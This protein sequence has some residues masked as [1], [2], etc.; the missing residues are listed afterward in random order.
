MTT[1][2][3]ANGRMLIRMLNGAVIWIKIALFAALMW[4]IMT[5]V[6]HAGVRPVHYRPQT[7][8]Y[9]MHDHHHSQPVL[10]WVLTGV[11]VGI[12]AY[13]ITR[14]PCRTGPVCVHF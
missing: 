11:I 9:V 7:R 5:S 6:S 14:R 8:V 13:D 4:G 3:I 12:V 10:P 2:D 1:K